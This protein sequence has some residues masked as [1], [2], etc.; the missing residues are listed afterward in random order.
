MLNQDLELPKYPKHFTKQQARRTATR[1]EISRN[2]KDEAA[3]LSLRVFNIL[4]FCA[5]ISFPSVVKLG[6][7]LTEVKS[8]VLCLKILCPKE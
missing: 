1:H 7:I 2:Q 4:P 8:K 5:V 3:F 6:I